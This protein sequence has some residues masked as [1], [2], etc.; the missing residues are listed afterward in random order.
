MATYAKEKG[1]TVQ[2]LS[3]D[4]VASQVTGGSWAS[5]TSI[6]NARFG[7]AGSTAGS[8]TAALIF[9]GDQMPTEPRM[10]GETELWNGSSWTELNDLNTLRGSSGGTGTSTAALCAGGSAQPPSFAS[11]TNVELFDGSSWTETTDM[12]NERQHKVHQVHKLLLFNLEVKII[13]LLLLT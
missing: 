7:V 4:P 1:F 3:T 2:T 9:A 6:N 8:S 11:T 13:H 5:I 12:T 10:V